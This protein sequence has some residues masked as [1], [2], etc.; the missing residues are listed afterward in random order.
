MKSF[1]ACTSRS[2]IPTAARRTPTGNPRLTSTFSLA[3][4]TSGS[5]TIRSSKKAT[6]SS[7]TSAS[8]KDLLSGPTE[9]Q[10]QKSWEM[11]SRIWCFQYGQSWP[12]CGPQL[13][14]EWRIAL[15]QRTSERLEGGAL[16]SPPSLQLAEQNVEHADR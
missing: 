2:E 11:Y 16:L 13:S 9:N 1:P 14:S 12:P 6:T 15:L 4:A 7:N 10:V 8:P 5:T 3:S